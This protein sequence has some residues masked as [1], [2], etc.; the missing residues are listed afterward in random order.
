MMFSFFMMA[1]TYTISIQP[2]KRAE[3]RGEKAWKEC[4]TYRSIG[5][6]F[7]L[8]SVINL[9]LWIWYPL[10]VVGEWI[11]SENIW[12]GIVIG[13]AILVPCLII[14]T[15]GIK[16]AGKETLSPSKETEM[17][18]GIYSYIR[19]PQTLG[20][21]PTFIALAFMF[22]SWFLVILSTVFIGLYT[23][24]MIHYEEKDLIKRFGEKYVKYQE[25]TGALF[26][27]FHK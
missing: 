4:K 16:D 6:L 9:V 26:P 5:G 24:I 18:G 8:V 22:N 20:E 11:I 27:K 3:K 15:V 19:H 10:P 23:P 25:K 7:E 21:F 14:M 1:I 12:V 13:I 17:Y 2:M